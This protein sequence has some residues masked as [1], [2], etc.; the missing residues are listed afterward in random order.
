M[1]IKHKHKRLL[2]ELLRLKR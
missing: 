2:G 1:P